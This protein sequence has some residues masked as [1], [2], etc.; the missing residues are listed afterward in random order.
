MNKQFAIFGLITALLTL[1]VGCT[2]PEIDTDDNESATSSLR[3]S[4][5][6]NLSG[7]G[8]TRIP[9]YVFSDT[10][11]KE[12]D[13]SDNNL[14]GA[15][16]GEIRFLEKLEVLDASDNNMTGL[17]AEVGQLKN[18]R[19]LN[20]SNNELTGLPNELKNLSS[21]EVLNLSGNDYSTQD[22]EVIVDGLP[23]DTEIIID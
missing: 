18:L 12:L 23:K 17:P 4:T 13:V 10:H 5:T 7:Q 1:G 22:L 14:E 6:L 16:Q 9:E 8:L 21:L 20:L 11:L 2:I 3:G 19:I 15:I